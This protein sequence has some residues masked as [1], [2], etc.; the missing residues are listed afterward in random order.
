MRESRDGARKE[1]I[2]MAKTEMTKTEAEQ[3]LGL[4]GSYSKKDLNNAYR[5]KVKT[6]HPDMGGDNELMARIN[7]ANSYLKGFFKGLA[8]DAVITASGSDSTCTATQEKPAQAGEQS[9]PKA[10]ED[11]GVEEA[12]AAEARRAEAMAQPGYDERQRDMW[13]DSIDGG[14]VK[15][16]QGK[17][18]FWWY[19]RNGG[20]PES[21]A[22]E[23]VGVVGVPYEYTDD[24]V[25]YATWKRYNEDAENVAGS[26]MRSEMP[27]DG[28]VAAMWSRYQAH[29]ADDFEQEY[30]S[31]HENKDVIVTPHGNLEFGNGWV[32]NEVYMSDEQ[33]RE[34]W[35]IA[36][37]PFEYAD[38]RDYTEWLNKN[39]NA[40]DLARLKNESVEGK[41]EKAQTS[42]LRA[43]NKVNWTVWARP[44]V[45]VLGWVLAI[46]LSGESFRQA[47]DAFSMKQMSSLESGVNGFGNGV[48]LTL[49]GIITFA[50]VLFG[51]WWGGG[52]LLDLMGIAK[53]EKMD[54][55]D[56]EKRKASVV[57]AVASAAKAGV[58]GSGF[59][60][61]GN[62]KKTVDRVDERSQRQAAERD[63][64]EAQAAKG[65]AAGDSCGTA[66]EST[67]E[68]KSTSRSASA[69]PRSDASKKRAERSARG[70]SRSS[71]SRSTNRG[72]RAAGRGTRSHR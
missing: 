30:A 7:K 3:L 25:S 15:T 52:K 41:V 16:P 13:Q 21:R 46:L 24:D 50:I 36:G 64:K 9:R 55:Q 37:V 4:S 49:E 68:S 26:T 42:F 70:G 67:S 53:A 32:G 51:V 39:K 23:W 5:E 33:F 34:W 60:G 59:F 57:S 6:A 20:Y 45:V 48:L 63:A 14:W 62:H 12:R 38:T 17:V 65:S 19:D 71:A 44:A 27:S 47:A 61:G 29:L 35:G 72:S 10:R 56:S 8:D 22:G 18:P 54:K 66:K 40:D 43:A 28:E 31:W 2:R 11:K 58:D 69:S 1:V